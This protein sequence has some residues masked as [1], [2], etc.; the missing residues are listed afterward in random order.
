MPIKLPVKNKIKE[1]TNPLDDLNR[2]QR[3]EVDAMLIDGMKA[4]DVAAHMKEKHGVW[5]ERSDESL[6]R[7]LNRYRKKDLTNR[8]IASVMGVEKQ[9]P[10]KLMK[11]LDTMGELESLIEI[12][13][14]RFLKMYEK[15]KDSPLLMAGVTTEAMNL[16]KMLQELARLQLETGTI[17]RAPKLI[18][19][20]VT[21]EHGNV[22]DFSWSEEQGELYKMLEQVTYGEQ[23]H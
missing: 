11:N 4:Q 5:A 12:Q 8:V 6:K 16:Q 19:G 14:A 10:I 18:H 23:S 20:S 1:Q 7:A 15:E 13:K 2:A 21:D 9:D 3:G 17:K 22:R